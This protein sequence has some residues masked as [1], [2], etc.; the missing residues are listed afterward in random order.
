MKTN[1]NRRKD[2]YKICMETNTNNTNNKKYVYKIYMK[3]NEAHH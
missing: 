3:T 1:T 2:V